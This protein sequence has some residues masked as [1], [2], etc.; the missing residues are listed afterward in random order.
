MAKRTWSVTAA[1]VGSKWMGDYEA[2]TGEEAL[3]MAREKADVSLC[4]QCSDECEDPQIEHMSAESNGEVVTDEET[5]EDRARAAKW[6]P[7]KAKKGARKR[8][9]GVP[10][11]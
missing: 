6:T 3:E 1:V 11:K 5:W 4:H 2:E 10:A 7:P 9:Q 8:A